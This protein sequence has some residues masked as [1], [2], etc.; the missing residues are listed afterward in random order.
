MY[1]IIQFPDLC[2]YT[3]QAFVMTNLEA[4]IFHT[5]NHGR[6]K[7]C[8]PIQSGLKT[9]FCGN[10]GLQGHNARSCKTP[11]DMFVVSSSSSSAS[12]SPGGKKLVSFPKCFLLAR[13][14]ANYMH[15]IAASAGLK[16]F[17]SQPPFSTQRVQEILDLLE[18][19]KQTLEEVHLMS[20]LYFLLQVFD[21]LIRLF[22]L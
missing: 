11:Q 13:L 5:P 14:G 19:E 8:A 1:D 22:F 21:F 20:L 15:Q 9:H 12:S 3:Y 2:Q 6:P 16:K 10:C 4:P 18:V 17:N 7:K